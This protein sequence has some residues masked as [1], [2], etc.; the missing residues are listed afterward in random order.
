MCLVYLVGRGLYLQCS[1]YISE[2]RH[3]L[4]CKEWASEYILVDELDV[5]DFSVAICLLRVVMRIVETLLETHS[6]AKVSVPTEF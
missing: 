4:F 3:A 5:C 6:A 2:V 1:S